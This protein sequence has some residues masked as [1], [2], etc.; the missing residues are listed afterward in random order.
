M[1][2]RGEIEPN[3]FWDQKAAA[4]RKTLAEAIAETSEALS[5]PHISNERRLELEEQ[6]EPLKF[7]LKMADAY[8]ARR[9]S[10]H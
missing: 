7:Y 8:L 5:S 6:V 1:L 10:L 9:R 3:R 2:D 4:F